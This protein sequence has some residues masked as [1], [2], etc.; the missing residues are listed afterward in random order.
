MN[1]A[2]LFAVIGIL[3]AASLAWGLLSTSV[4]HRTSAAE[5]SLGAEVERMFG[6][7]LV[8]RAPR[9]WERVLRGERPAAVT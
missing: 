6:P 8:Q 4:S 3:L 5:T 2:R 9:H 7:P 1:A